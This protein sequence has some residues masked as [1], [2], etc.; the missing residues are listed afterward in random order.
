MKTLLE[1]AGCRIDAI[2]KATAWLTDTA[3]FA[4]YNEVY[5]AAFGD[6]PPCRSTVCSALM[7]PGAVVEIEVM[8]YDPQ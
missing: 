1:Q 5:G 4:A 2:V 6:T 7:W 8:A 3:N